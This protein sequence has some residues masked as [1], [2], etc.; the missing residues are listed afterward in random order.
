MVKNLPARAGNTKDSGL[1]PGL[2]RSPGEG[3]GNPLQ[4]S[5]LENLMYRGAWRATLHG[6]TPRVRHDWVTE[7]IFYN[8]GELSPLILATIQWAKYYFYFHLSDKMKPHGVRSSFCVTK[9]VLGRTKQGLTGYRICTPNQVLSHPYA[10]LWDSPW[11]LRCTS[12]PTTV[13]F[14]LQNW[15]VLL[16]DT[17]ALEVSSTEPSLSV[18]PPFVLS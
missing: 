13:W 3:N 14:I 18:S 1:I 11:S 12:P 9:L 2:G 8:C 6:A 4:Y 15:K 7:H 16:Q 17:R 5:C 10:R